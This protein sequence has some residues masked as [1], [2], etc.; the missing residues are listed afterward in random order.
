MSIQVHQC[1]GLQERIKLRRGGHIENVHH[2]HCGT[3]CQWR[4]AHPRGGTSVRSRSKSF[5]NRAIIRGSACSLVA[6]PAL[7]GP[8]IVTCV[9]QRSKATI[10][11]R[12]E[13]YYRQNGQF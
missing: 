10:D 11:Q 4:S 9:G 8:L 1:T 5:R 6:G 2:S 12:C 7:R 3:D 13:E